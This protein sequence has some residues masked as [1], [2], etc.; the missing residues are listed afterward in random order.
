[1]KILQ[2]IS[3]GGFYGAESVLVNLSTELERIGHHC[4]VGV[5]ENSANRNTDTNAALQSP[6]LG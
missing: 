1:M 6:P 2:L 5:F 4:V 3:S